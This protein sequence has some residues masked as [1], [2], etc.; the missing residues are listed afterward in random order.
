MGHE[1][2]V[3]SDHHAQ[4][5]EANALL[6]TNEDPINIKDC[7][8]DKCHH[9]IYCSVDCLFACK[10]VR[11]SELINTKIGH[12]Y[13]MGILWNFYS[14]GFVFA[15]ATFAFTFGLV[16]YIIHMFNY[17]HYNSADFRVGDERDEISSSWICYRFED[18][19]I[20]AEY[21]EWNERTQIK[22]S[23]K[24]LGFALSC[25]L[26]AAVIDA[27]AATT[28]KNNCTDVDQELKSKRWIFFRL[29]QAGTFLTMIA[30]TVVLNWK[31]SRLGWYCTLSM[32]A[33]LIPAGYLPP[34]YY[35]CAYLVQACEEAKNPIIK[36]QRL[37]LDCSLGGR[38]ASHGIMLWILLSPWLTI[39]H[40][41][42][43]MVWGWL[44]GICAMWSLAYD[45]LTNLHIFTDVQIATRF[46]LYSVALLLCVDSRR[47]AELSNRQRYRQERVTRIV[48]QRMFGVLYDMMPEHIVVPMMKNMGGTVAEESHCATVLF[49]FIDGFEA[50]TKD[51]TPTK[52]LDFLNSYFGKFD[53]IFEEHEVTKIETVG[54]EY[55][56]A[57]GV[58][59]KDRHENSRYGHG[60]LLSRLFDAVLA[61][62]N[63]KGVD[64]KREV[65]LK[66]GLQTGSIV[67]GVVGKKLPRYRLFGDTINS[68]A[69]MMQK[70]MPGTLQFGKETYEKLSKELRDIVTYR[71]EVEMKGKGMVP[72]WVF[73]PS[74]CCTDMGLGPPMPGLNSQKAM[75]GLTSQKKRNDDDNDLNTALH[76]LQM[77]RRVM[78]VGDLDDV[79]KNKAKLANK[80]QRNKLF[81]DALIQIRSADNQQCTL[82]EPIPQ[83][84][85]ELWKQDFGGQLFGRGRLRRVGIFSVILL[86]MTIFEAAV[87]CR[88]QIYRYDHAV[89]DA[90]DRAFWFICYR[91]VTILCLLVNWYCGDTQWAEKSPNL[92]QIILLC[93]DLTALVSC[94]LSYDALIYS[95][96]DRWAKLQNQLFGNQGYL[97]A[98]DQ[99]FGLHAVLAVHVILH[100]SRF[101]AWFSIAWIP[102]IAVFLATSRIFILF[103]SKKGATDIFT[104]NA[105]LL[106]IIQVFLRIAG[107]LQMENLNRSVFKS[108]RRVRTLQIHTNCILDNLLPP[109]VTQDMRNSTSQQPNHQYRHA[110]IAQS[111][112]CGFTK[113][114]A[115]KTPHEIVKF[116]MELFG[117]FDDLSDYYKIYKVETV[118]D[119]YIAGMADKPLTAEYLPANVIVFGLD[120]VR[121]VDDWACAMNVKVT[122]RVGIH[123]GEC[124]GGIVGRRAQRYHL[125][126]KFMQGLEIL[127]STSIEGRVQVS[128]ACRKEV[129]RQLLDHPC[130]VAEKIRFDLRRDGELKTSKGEVHKY[131]E[132]GG[133]TWLVTSDAPLRRTDPW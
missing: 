82:I 8:C 92:F 31:P 63:F 108:R 16:R 91:L 12:Y 2:D 69:R 78:Q 5:L 1:L 67:A 121:A 30:A 83:R 115:T 98:P 66:M 106:F 120:M 3:D 29:V 58:V 23:C 117:S 93:L 64:K 89:Y 87:A 126:G 17:Y 15:M 99:Q 86:S 38:T 7:D 75:P 10:V 28:S 133:R 95:N 125:F 118:G 60:P 52:V 73:S 9:L 112:L 34:F 84:N 53:D 79:M 25:Q 70:G 116:M 124:I 27:L 107:A 24:M 129:Q 130:A 44:F 40:E 128:D 54:E 105:K 109:L 49:I 45:K 97:P 65:K 80:S 72:T 26:L 56:A 51:M 76:A 55:V 131:D 119:A 13:D 68:A 47:S 104:W 132:V 35:S 71:G 103:S 48:G 88:M 90:S 101:R 39:R 6:E 96:A 77:T 57:V 61:V 123:Y 32:S 94:G 46:L 74:S 62:L 36:F 81:E 110:V 85:F 102:G 11:R 114:A 21:H 41:D 50:V 59:P 113:L 19:T 14:I 33:L 42:I 18:F 43:H 20:E 127:E 111:D 100:V 37:T 4:I 22:S 122:C